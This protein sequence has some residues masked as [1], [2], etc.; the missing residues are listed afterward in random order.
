MEIQVELFN[1]QEYVL[2][3]KYIFKGEEIYYFGNLKGEIYC[4]KEADKYISVT[5]TYKNYLLKNVLGSATLK[6]NRRFYSKQIT[7]ELFNALRAITNNT[8]Y[9]VASKKISPELREKIISEQ[10]EVFQNAKQKLGMNFNEEQVNTVIEETE[11]RRIP[12][13]I[14]NYFGMHFP[15]LYTIIYADMVINKW[16]DIHSKRTRFHEAIHA[17]TGESSI[18]YYLCFLTGLLEGQTENLTEAFYG[19]QVSHGKRYLGKN[20]SGEAF[21]NFSGDAGYEELLSIIQ[22]MEVATGQKSYDSIVNG[23]L[24]FE[25]DFINKYGLR[26]FIYLAGKTN[27]IKNQISSPKGFQDLEILANTQDR[28][29][30]M[31]F[32][33]DF[34]D[35]HSLKDAEN[36]FEKLRNFERVRAKVYYNGEKENKK[37]SGDIVYKQYYEQKYKEAKQLLENLGISEEE[38]ERRL[39]SYKYQSQWFWPEEKGMDYAKKEF[40]RAI[41]NDNRGKDSYNLED[42]TLVKVTRK[43]GKIDYYVIKN[44]KI[45]TPTFDIDEDTGQ[46]QFGLLIREIDSLL[47]EEMAGSKIEEIPNPMTRQEIEK[48]FEIIA[49]IEE[50]ANLNEPSPEQSLVPAKKEN[51][52]KRVFNKIKNLFANQKLLKQD[53]SPPEGE[54]GEKEE[55]ISFLGYEKLF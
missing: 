42:Y 54:S 1:N 8:K 7:G 15:L 45:Y 53:E 39:E 46:A 23:D 20:S 10:K 11:Y 17:Q 32:D 33:K 19:K 47:V 22:Q 35:I 48:E 37:Y 3:N 29:L 31:V 50:K 13:K 6:M 16:N 27:T 43:T 21:F 55:R 30:Q 5:D 4:T 40:A 26:N 34:E 2:I 18:I 41:Y 51:V 44:N 38:I 14:A 9:I 49:Q 36:Y 28:L 12:N 24:S 52:F 25:V